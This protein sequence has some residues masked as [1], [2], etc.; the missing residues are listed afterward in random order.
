MKEKVLKYLKWFFESF[1][2]LGLIL[3]IIDI[4]TKQIVIANKA[5][6]LAQGGIDLIP[7]F[8]RINYLI[9]NTL[10]FGM[11]L[12]S[13]MTNRIVFCVVALA[14][15]IGLI[16]WLVLKWKTVGKFYR[17][18]FMMIL[19]GAFGNVIDRLFYSPEYLGNSVNG[20]VD[21]I[22]FY[23]IWKFNF[24]IADSAVVVAAFMLIIYLIVT[25]IID[26]VKKNKDQ[27]KEEKK[28]EGKVL[29]KTE[30]EQNKYHE[31]NK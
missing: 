10:V 25:E 19:S 24:N 23:G 16:T 1:I 26:Y 18:T 15:I 17:A 31:D 12:G 30:Q 6:I 8:L 27:P 22:D 7:G 21:W 5:D 29:S 4:V 20:V 2:W 11:T 28:D 9:N 3:L 13:D 14:I